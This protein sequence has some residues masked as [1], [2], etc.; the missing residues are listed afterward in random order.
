[1]ELKALYTATGLPVLQNK[2]YSSREEALSCPTGDVILAQSP[3][4]GLISNIAFDPAIVVYDQIIKT[5]RGV[6]HD[7]KPISMKSKASSAGISKARHSSMWAAEKADF[8]GN[9]D[10]TASQ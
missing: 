2:T 8:S 3:E 5:S 9:S 1:M 10:H 6:L 7:F 4:T